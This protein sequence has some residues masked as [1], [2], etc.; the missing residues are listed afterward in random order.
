[1]LDDLTFADLVGVI[2][3]M[4]ICSAYYAVST[5]RMDAGRA[6]YQWMNAI[7]SILLLISLWF[8]PNPG[9]ILIEVL[10]LAIAATSLTRIWR[11]KG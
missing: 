6:P 2:G 1:M 8:R 4:T 3:S 5:G 11:R 7:G 9:A 10:W